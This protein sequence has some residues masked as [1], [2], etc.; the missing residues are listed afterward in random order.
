MW[1]FF[2]LNLISLIYDIGIKR[3]ISVENLVQNE[4]IIVRRGRAKVNTVDYAAFVS[5]IEL[6]QE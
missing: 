4:A 3:V 6:K 5:N 2:C 1:L